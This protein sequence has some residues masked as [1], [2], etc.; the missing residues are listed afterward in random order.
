MT[1][2]QTPDAKKSE[3][4]QTP[5]TLFKYCSNRV[6]LKVRKKDEACTNFSPNSSGSS[7]EAS[8]HNRQLVDHTINATQ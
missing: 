8:Q 3:C 1:I 7:A 4:D 2:Y 6:R 5:I